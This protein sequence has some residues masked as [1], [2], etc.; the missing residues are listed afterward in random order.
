MV[1]IIWIITKI[2]NWY[3]FLPSYC[4]GQITGLASVLGCFLEEF[5]ISGVKCGFIDIWKH[6]EWCDCLVIC[7]RF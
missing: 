3:S 5:S 2:F 4:K 1:V 6:L 7:G